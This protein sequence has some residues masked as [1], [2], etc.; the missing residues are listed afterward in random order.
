ML[1]QHEHGSRGMARSYGPSQLTS[2]VAKHLA[3][4]ILRKLSNASWELALSSKSVNTTLRMTNDID[5]HAR[6]IIE[7]HAALRH[8]AMIPR[9]RAAIEAR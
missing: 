3:A 6:Q 1:Q 8:L 7:C 9:A 5:W 4:T 2:I